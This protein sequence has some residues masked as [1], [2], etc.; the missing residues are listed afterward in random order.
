MPIHQL[1]QKHSLC[2]GNEANIVFRIAT[3][4]GVANNIYCILLSLQPGG[5]KIS[6]A[7]VLA[8]I[9]TTKKCRALINIR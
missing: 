8:V 1:K 5:Q 3:C 7:H 2:H 9:H 6:I 4:F